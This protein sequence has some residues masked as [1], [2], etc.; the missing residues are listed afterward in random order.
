MRSSD[1]CP[2][3]SGVYQCEQPAG[4]AGPCETVEPARPW[5]GPAWRAPLLQ[6][7]G[8]RSRIMEWPRA[9]TRMPQD[10][11]ATSATDETPS[12]PPEAA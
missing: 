11:S 1:R 3:R 7:T 5:V 6:Q 2:T 10:A 9:V 8:V 4:H 12:D